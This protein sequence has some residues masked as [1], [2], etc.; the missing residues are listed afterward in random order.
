MFIFGDIVWSKINAE[1]INHLGLRNAK[2]LTNLQE[3]L[4]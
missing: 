2:C 3:L 4:G 1:T